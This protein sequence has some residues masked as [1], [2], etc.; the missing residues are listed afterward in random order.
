M[1]INFSRKRSRWPAA[2]AL[3]LSLLFA[4]GC[5]DES[6]GMPPLLDGGAALAAQ[7]SESGGALASIKATINPHDRE[8]LQ[9]ITEGYPK[10]E[11]EV[12]NTSWG[13]IVRVIV[14]EDYFSAAGATCRRATIV[15]DDERVDVVVKKL[16]DDAWEL[17]K[18]IA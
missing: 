18:S 14:G 2:F 1:L 4:V 3:S 6:A 11:G 13:S 17:V 9:F 5:E 12:H 7:G 15:T 8:L 10:L 16:A